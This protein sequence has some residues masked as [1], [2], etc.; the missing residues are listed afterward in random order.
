MSELSEEN[1]KVVGSLSPAF[2]A[3]VAARREVGE[4]SVRKEMERNKRKTF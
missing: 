1:L 4:R 2:P 3:E